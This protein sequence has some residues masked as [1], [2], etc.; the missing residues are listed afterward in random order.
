MTMRIN[1]NS[2]L[3][4]AFILML[5]IVSG[6]VFAQN[7][8]VSGVITDSQT[9]EPIIG[10]SVA[11]KGTTTGTFSDEN[12][13]YSIPASRNAVLTASF[14]GYES[15]E[16]TV[17]NEVLNFTMVSQDFQFDEIVVVGAAFKKSDLTGAVGS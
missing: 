6:G 5:F 16:I 1:I 10:V 11:V 17:T 12:G 13:R 3:K 2:K 9:K 8:T 7:I 15:K 14:L 4:M